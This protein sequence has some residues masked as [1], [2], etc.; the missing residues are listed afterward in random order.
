MRASYADLA[1]APRAAAG[2]VDAP[3]GPSPSAIWRPRCGRHSSNGHPKAPRS[4]RRRTDDPLRAGAAMRVGLGP[5]ELGATPWWDR[6]A[7]A[8]AEAAAGASRAAEDRRSGDAL[9][10][11]VRRRASGCDR[12]C[13]FRRRL[14][15]ARRRAAPALRR[16]STQR[17]A[18]RLIARARQAT[19]TRPRAIGRE[20]LEQA[21][22]PL[23]RATPSDVDADRGSRRRRRRG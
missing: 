16:R 11:Q 20:V 22:A 2:D 19:T 12:C 7:G 14:G 13:D 15:R 6:G 21:G 23:H 9:R 17:D 18:V 3:A 10:R 5:S 8:R 1:R 4:N